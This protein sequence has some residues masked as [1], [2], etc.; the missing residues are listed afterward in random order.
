M[1]KYIKQIKE[2]WVPCLFIALSACNWQTSEEMKSRSPLNDLESLYK[3]D[4]RE[5]IVHLDSL[6]HLNS[7]KDNLHYFQKARASFKKLEPILAYVDKNN[8]KA[9]N[10]PNL[11]KVEEEDFTNIK[12]TDPFGYQVIEEMLHD[13]RVSKEDL[14][15][16]IQLTRNRLIL[17]LRN[18]HLQLKN[19]HIL[20]LLREEIVRLATMGITGFDSPVL[21]NSL[22]ESRIA[23]QR[24]NNILT[25]YKGNFSNGNLFQLWE[26][27]FAKTGQILKADFNS[28]DRYTFIKEHTHKQLRLLV[29]TQEDWKIGFPF[30]KALKNDIISLFSTGT[31]NLD[32]FTGYDK[33]S[34][35]SE[36]KAMLGERLF[37]DK[38]L[39]LIKHMSCAS[40]HKKDLAFTDGLKKFPKQKRNSPTLL[41]AALQKGFFY[42]NRA[43]SLEGQVSFVVKNENEFH[44]DLEELKTFVQ[45]DG[46]YRKEFDQLYKRGVTDQNIRNAIA[47]YVRSLINFNSKFDRNINEEENTL[48]E[49]EIKG[50]NLFMGKAKCATCHFPP[51]FNGT[52]PPDF[53]HTELES[54]G[55]PK[56]NSEKPGI[57]DDLGRFDLFGTEER[58]Y[59][60]KTPTVRNISKTT[61]YMHNGVYTTLEEVL[62]FYNKGGGIGLGIQLEHQT[63]PEVP[64][65]L[66]EQEIQDIVSFMNTLYD[67]Y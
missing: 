13:E 14:M 26:N 8:Y 37:S 55:V 24:L 38:N 46:S 56:D 58:K 11:L 3:S 29:E 42:D 10:Q 47:S 44:S 7:E 40:C 27:E 50:F 5:C 16:N 9:L 15:K 51:V 21:E 32:Y 12:I 30:E 39:S 49:G 33:E 34:A 54:L 62:D 4:L 18:T 63:L 2:A 22:E 48:T 57:D 28:F 35:Y 43:G 45:K 65:D 23:Y 64:L 31:F 1:R 19:Y 52:V 41:Y 60:F 59:F 53:A 36:K 61:P 20:W 66:S 25:L 6:M 17:I 67:I